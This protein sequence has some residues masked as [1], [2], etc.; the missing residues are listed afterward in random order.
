MGLTGR[1]LGGV[2]LLGASPNASR[3][4]PVAVRGPVSSR[5]S[6]GVPPVEVRH[7]RNLL[8][9]KEDRGSRGDFSRSGISASTENRDPRYGEE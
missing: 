9:R 1:A 2:S 5:V 3:R 6:C 4:G 7:I 8:P